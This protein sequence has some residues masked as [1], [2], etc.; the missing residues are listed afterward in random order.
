MHRALV[1]A[2]PG[3]V[4]GWG[5]VQLLCWV[6]AGQRVRAR[7]PSLQGPPLCACWKRTREQADLHLLGLVDGCRTPHSR[8]R[9]LHERLG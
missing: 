8:C 2:A 3:Q 6:Q 7:S 5:C 9:W 1:Q 4:H